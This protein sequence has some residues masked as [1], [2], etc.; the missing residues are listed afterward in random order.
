MGDT[1]QREKKRITSKGVRDLRKMPG[2]DPA[3]FNRESAADALQALEDSGS[4]SRAYAD[5]SDCDAC[6]SER[7]HTGDDTAL[8]ETHLME[9]MGL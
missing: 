3:K 8:C 1:S 5:A 4:Q 6:V 9:A 2:W 7:H